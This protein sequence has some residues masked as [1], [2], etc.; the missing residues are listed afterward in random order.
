MGG[1]RF[2][3]L[4]Y[5]NFAH[6]FLSK[7]YKT[8]T[9][10]NSIMFKTVLTLLLLCP[11]SSF[12]AQRDVRG[13]VNGD[14]KVNISDVTAMINSLL[15]S[16]GSYIYEC[17]VNY[18]RK[19]NISDVTELINYLLSGAW[20][21]PDYAGPPIPG[22]AEIYT[23]NG[24]SFAMIPVEGGTFDFM[25][26]EPHPTSHEVTL[27]NYK[28]GMTE[29]TQELWVA[30]MG[31]NPSFYNSSLLQPVNQISYY[32]CEDFIAHLN[33]L[34]GINFCFPTKEQ[35][36]FA[37]RGGNLSHGYLYSG[38]DD[39]NEVAWYNNDNH[40]GAPYP[41]GLKMPNELGLYDMSGNVNEWVYNPYL[42]DIAPSTISLGGSAHSDSK[43][44]TVYSFGTTYPSDVSPVFG[45]RLAIMPQ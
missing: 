30:V 20:S 33:E 15:S 41:V 10:R 43:Y 1:V 28:I 13:D 14:N 38:S 22:N 23:V 27:G 42:L 37:A 45:L 2:I 4:K 18:D 34:T 3:R 44:C 8:Y 24:V 40:L 11:L 36:Q 39:I 16:G 9:M 5:G 12:G 31:E 19:T 21:T 26:Y 7:K 25:P 17:D 35:W 32:D 29:V 6:S